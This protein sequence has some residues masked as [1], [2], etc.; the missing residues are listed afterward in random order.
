MPRSGRVKC[1][2]VA[3]IIRSAVALVGREPPHGPARQVEVV[4]GLEGEVA[5]VAE[6]IARALRGRTAAGRRR[7]CGPGPASARPASRSAS[8]SAALASTLGASQGEARRRVQRRQVEG[9]RAAAAPRSC[10]SRWA[11]GDDGRRRRGRRS[12][13][14]TP[15]ARRCPRACRRGPGANARPCA[16]RTGIQ[17]RLAMAQASPC[18]GSTP[19]RIWSASMRLEQGLEVALAEALVALALDDL[20]E[21]RPDHVLGEDLQQQALALGR[22]RRRP[23]CGRRAAAAG[24]RRGRARGRRAAR[25][26]CRACPGTSTPALAHGLH[27]VEDV[28]RAQR[29]VLDALAAVV[30]CRNSSICEWSSWLSLSGMRILP[31]GLVIAL[32]IRPVCWPS[33]SK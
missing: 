25:S 20:E 12:P 17:L 18:A 33:M 21:D 23:G 32:E 6:E 28:V 15:R 26:R 14:W 2:P 19:R 7:R 1:A 3:S 11:G 5:V 29:D 4:A 16:P 9:A 8:R 10:S 31:S 22:A 30:A 27:R 13:P 24:S